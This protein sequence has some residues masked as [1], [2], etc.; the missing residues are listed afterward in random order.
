MSFYP[1]ILSGGSGT[2]LWPL[3]VGN[4][5]KQFLS[6]VSENTMIQETLLRL[7]GIEHSEPVVVCNEAHRF[8]VA[9]Q[10]KQIGVKNPGIILEPVAKNTA[11]AIASA[12]YGVMQKDSDGVVIVL[13]SDHVIKNKEVFQT[14][15]KKAIQEAEKGFLVTF[16]IVPTEPNTGY[17]YIKTGMQEDGAFVLEKFVEKPN[18]EK[19]KEYLADGNYSW[20]SGMFVFKASVFLS[21]LK[22]FEPEMYDKAIK[23][24]ENA[25]VDADFTRL[26]KGDFETIKGNSIDYAVMEKTK[27]GKVVKL[28][29]GW[30]DVG[31]WS[32]LWE[33][34][35]KDSD[36]N[37]I[38]GNVMNLGSKNCYINSKDFFTGVIGLED[39]V[40]VTSKEGILISK[41]DKVQDVKIIAEELKKRNS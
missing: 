20:N 15:V 11:P 23:A 14:A 31:S 1:V 21:E 28:D 19:A 32:A 35:E 37:V 13:P 3:S 8:I 10:L 17:G 25:A 30:N 33:I 40:V 2:R 18:L 5:P 22:K 38:S 39:I 26:N 16:G 12:C 9:E 7:D 29:A 36:G 41:K 34:K 6:L 24:Y 27:L 4:H